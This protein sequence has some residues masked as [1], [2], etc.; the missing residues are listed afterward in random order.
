M[1]EVHSTA[2]ITEQELLS[3]IA[4]SFLPAVGPVLTR[5]LVGHCGSAEAVFR[6]KR[7]LLARIPG[8]GARRISKAFSAPVFPLAERELAFIRR[9]RIQPIFFTDA[10]Y[11]H[12]LIQCHDAP[13]LLYS[14]G[15]AD[16]NS[17]R[18]LAIV[19]TRH[20]T[21]YGLLCVEQLLAGL[22]PYGVCIVSGLAYGIDIRA[23]QAAL[24]NGL[25]TI[26]VTA[27]GLD[28]IYPPA[29]RATA[30]KMIGS[31]GL[32]TEY[33]SGTQPDRE[34]FPSRNRIVAGISD[35]V[36]VVEAAE[37]G[38]ALITADL[39]NGYDRDVFAI[40]G[41]V[42]DVRS[43]G[44]NRLIR[45]HKAALITSA[46]DLVWMMGWNDE[47]QNKKSQ[48]QQTQLFPELSPEQQRIVDVLRQVGESGQDAIALQSGVNLSRIPG[49]L[50][51]LELQGILKLLPGRRYRLN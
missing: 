21:E 13:A 17:G 47:G 24:N 12:R 29:H 6:E 34:N 39:A 28:R 23:H 2:S 42:G 40:P 30:K 7:S 27:H 5:A 16:F 22:A 46:E 8:L 50:L 51:E 49:V 4:L 32:L 3:R 26:G 44:C 35:A 37:K 41:R 48:V 31:G 14:K 9:H 10:S 15:K 43:M 18:Y 33:P 45:E 19:G 11:P 38:G 1:T 25:S 36:V 20:A